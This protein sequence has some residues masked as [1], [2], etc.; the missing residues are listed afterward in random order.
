MRRRQPAE[1][2]SVY[3]GFST[4]HAAP[5]ARGMEGFAY[6]GFSTPH[7][8]PSARGMGG[9]YSHSIVDGGFDEMSYATRLIPGTSLITRDEIEANT[10]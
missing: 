5:S 6:P 1:Q 8:A 7:A 9:V 4:P 10:S 2:E 3:P